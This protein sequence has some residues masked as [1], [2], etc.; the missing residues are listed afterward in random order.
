MLYTGVL[1]A[2]YFALAGLRLPWELQRLDRFLWSLAECWWRQQLRAER[3]GMLAAPA[4]G[5]LGGQRLR[6]MVSSRE[7]LHELLF[8]A[9]WS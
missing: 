8:S 1:S 5:E 9:P 3:K 4:R 2:L 6:E 7:E